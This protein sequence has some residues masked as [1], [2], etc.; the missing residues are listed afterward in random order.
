MT[1]S[2][3][4]GMERASGEQTRRPNVAPNAVAGMLI[5]IVAEV[6]FFAAFI[7]AFTIDRAQERGPWPPPGQPR[8]PIEATAINTFALLASGVAM[9]LA[10]RAYR[11]GPS[12]ARAPLLASLALGAFFLVSQGREWVEL[13]GQGLTLRTSLH[14]SFFYLIVGAH[15]LHVL[16]GLV[17]LALAYASVRRGKDAP[18]LFAAAKLFWYFVVLLWPVL[19]L[20][21]YW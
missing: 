9:Y 11:R 10:A 21:V 16:S 6:M 20:R 15:G 17:A 19:Y 18:G 8:L 7:S 1:T 12:A 13:I 2:A 5:F 14:G 3:V 4:A